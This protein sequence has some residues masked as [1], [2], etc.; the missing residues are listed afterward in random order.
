MRVIS[1]LAIHFLPPYWW[2]FQWFGDATPL[3]SWL[4]MCLSCVEMSR[5]GI[6]E[7][8]MNGCLFLD[9]LIHFMRPPEHQSNHFYSD[10]WS[11]DD[12]EWTFFLLS[13]WPRRWNHKIHGKQENIEQWTMEQSSAKSNQWWYSKDSEAHRSVKLKKKA[14][15]KSH[16][17]T[18]CTSVYSIVGTFKRTRTTRICTSITPL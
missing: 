4:T 15:F 3:N 12:L 13:R 18:L 14:N 2:L 8:L 9:V 17:C 7:L 5:I 6:Y 11:E 1:T 10:R 16:V